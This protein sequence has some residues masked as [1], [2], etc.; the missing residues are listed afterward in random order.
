[1][2][3]GACALSSSPNLSHSTAAACFLP[4]PA[5]AVFRHGAPA[6]AVSRYGAPVG[7]HWHAGCCGVPRRPGRALLPARGACAASGRCSAAARRCS[8]AV[9]RDCVPVALPCAAPAGSSSESLPGARG[10]GYPI[11]CASGDFA[12]A[13]LSDL[14]SLHAAA[15]AG[16]SHASSCPCRSDDSRYGRSNSCSERRA[17]CAGGAS[18]RGGAASNRRG[19]SGDATRS[20]DCPNSNDCERGRSAGGTTSRPSSGDRSRGGHGSCGE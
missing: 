14:R 8:A 18:F 20:S 16:Q 2:T 17:G 15:R 9:D 12:A 13:R 5:A 1:M 6:A 19:Y 3:R 10:G 7:T 11:R 4:V